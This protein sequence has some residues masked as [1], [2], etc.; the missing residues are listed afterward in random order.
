MTPVE[1]VFNKFLH[2]ID[3]IELA[4]LDEEDIEEMLYQYLENA[5]ISFY[6]C[7]KSLN[8]IDDCI[9]GDLNLTEIYILALSMTQF[10][11][12]PKIK[13]EENLKQMMNDRDFN[14]ISS[15]NMLGKLLQLDKSIKEEL[16]ICKQRYAF[17][18]FKGFD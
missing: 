17:Q 13:R 1:S 2:F 3:D 5:T 18:N 10:W 6:E 9:E 11:L 14:Q 4:M 12:S 15:A 7:K 8:I 16:R